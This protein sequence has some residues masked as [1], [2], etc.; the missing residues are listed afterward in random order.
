MSKNIAIKTATQIFHYKSHITELLRGAQFVC[1]TTDIWSSTHRSFLGVTCHWIEEDL[2]RNSAVLS[3]R[4]FKGKHTYDKIA[5]LLQDTFTVYDLTTTKIVSVVTDNGSNFVKAFKEYGVT[6]E[7]VDRDQENDN[8]EPE[9]Q[10]LNIS[11][12]LDE[13]VVLPRHKRCASHTLSLVATTDA[14]KVR[15][16]IYLDI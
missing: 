4:R 1:I 13:G 5:E 9:E 6:P 12:I 10:L 8:N 3:L 7:T 14:E 2:T 15:T 16:R 11:D